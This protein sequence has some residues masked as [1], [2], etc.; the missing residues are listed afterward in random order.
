[1]AI[2][3]L[4]SKEELMGCVAECVDT[5]DSRSLQAYILEQRLADQDQF[6][7]LTSLLAPTLTSENL[8]KHPRFFTTARRCIALFARQGKAKEMVLALLEQLEGFKDDAM[9]LALLPCLQDS[10]LRLPVKRGRSLELVM[11]TLGCHVAGVPQPTNWN[12]EGEETKLLETDETIRRY[13]DIVPALLDF[14]KP[15]LDS[16]GEGGDTGSGRAWEKRV[17]KKH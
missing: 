17:L 9:F 1:M 12:L 6:W 5:L 14:M 11:D 8:E 16:V 10:L 2:P 15:F 4:S 3:P 7:D 13:I